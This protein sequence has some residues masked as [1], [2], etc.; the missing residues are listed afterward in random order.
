MRR[1]VVLVALAFQA[2]DKPPAS[3]PATTPGP[4]LP[5]L[6]K[7]RLDRS[8]AFARDFVEK[9]NPGYPSLT[10]RMTYG[11]PKTFLEF[12]VEAWEEGKRISREK[13]HQMFH[14][15]L[16]DDAAF[17]FSDGKDKEGKDVVRLHE[18]FPVKSKVAG[19][20]NSSRTGTTSEF[21]M[22]PLKMRSKRTLELAWPLEVADGTEVMLWAVF[23]DEPA[24][25][26]AGASPEERAKRAGAAWLFKIRTADEKAEEKK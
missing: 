21:G 9:A 4:S 7:L 22:A 10:V 13:N 23:V 8:G 15:P 20:G 19:D 25:V 24:D 2:C 5:P 3:P 17:G 16:A 11:G 18:S 26:P 6:G 1:V 14:L 12:Q